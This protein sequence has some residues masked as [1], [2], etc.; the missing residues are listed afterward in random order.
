MA[1]AWA[2]QPNLPRQGIKGAADGCAIQPCAS[3]GDEEGD[4][5]TSSQDSTTTHGVCREYLLG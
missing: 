3:P 5:V 4:G 1:G 2:T